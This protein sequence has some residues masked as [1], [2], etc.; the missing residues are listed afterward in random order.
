MKYRC[1]IIKEK[2]CGRLGFVLSVEVFFI[3]IASQVTLKLCFTVK[4]IKNQ[5]SQAMHK[6]CVWCP[7]PKKKPNIGGLI[8]GSLGKESNLALSKMFFNKYIVLS[9]TC[10]RFYSPTCEFNLHYNPMRQKQSLHPFCKWEHI[11]TKR[12]RHQL[13]VDREAVSIHSQAPVPPFHLLS[14]CCVHGTQMDT[15]NIFLIPYSDVLIN[16]PTWDES[17]QRISAVPL[18]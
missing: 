12:L 4:K 8:K 18:K 13:V 16:W 17:D 3:Q 5:K 15:R 11:G 10:V 14:G 6:A 7:P 2:N 1:L 9:D